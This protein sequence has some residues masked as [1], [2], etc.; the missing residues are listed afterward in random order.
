M[1]FVYM[2][3]EFNEEEAEDVTDFM[4][5]R[6]DEKWKYSVRKVLKYKKLY[7]VY[8]CLGYTAFGQEFR[9]TDTI[10]G[11]KWYSKIATLERENNYGYEYW[12]NWLNNNKIVWNGEKIPTFIFIEKQIKGKLKKLSTTNKL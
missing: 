4:K 6:Y 11:V 8:F 5:R 10:A 1:E 7:K 3:V 9:Y 2:D 12:K